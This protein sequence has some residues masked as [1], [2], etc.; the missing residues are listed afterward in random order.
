MMPSPVTPVI[1]EAAVDDFLADQGWQRQ[2]ARNGWRLTRHDPLT[3]IVGLRARP[4]DASAEEFTLRLSCDYYPT[5]P[6]DVRFVN[7]ETLA[8]DQASD[9]RHLPV[10]SAPYCY[11]HPA[12]GYSVAYRY[13][14]QLVCSSMTLGYYF[15][16]HN[17]TPEQRWDPDRYSIGTTIHT[18]HRALQSP[19]Y[20]GRHPG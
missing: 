3:L 5:W 12:Y 10:L 8:Y 9:Q 16:G 6:P 15:S 2:I 1:G 17:P 20:Q 19:H 13:G 18:V 11:L 4:I 14:P 7:P